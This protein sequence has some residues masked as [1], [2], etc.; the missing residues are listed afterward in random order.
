MVHEMVRIGRVEREERLIFFNTLLKEEVFKFVFW[1]K[2]D[3]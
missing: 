3:S 2:R 1:V